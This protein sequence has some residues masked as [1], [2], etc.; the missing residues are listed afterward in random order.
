MGLSFQLHS[1][2]YTICRLECSRPRNW[3]RLGAERTDRKK[4][5][6]A[7]DLREELESRAGTP[8]FGVA[9]AASYGAKAPEGHRPSDFMR[10]ARSIVLVGERML[11]A[12]LD[13]IP[14]TRQEYTANFHVA[15]DRLNHV[16]F[17][18]AGVLQAEGYRAF[19]VPY[20]E[21]PGWNLEGRSPLAL[22]LLRH[23]MTAQRARPLVEASLW[24]NLSY[25]HMA[26]EAGL[27]ELG[28]N[29]LLLHPEHG[30]RV[31]FVALLTD[32]EMQAG[33]PLE[34]ALCRPEL[35]GHACARACPAGALSEEGGRTDRPACLK[36]YIKLGIPGQSGVRCG[37]C[38]AKCPV[39]RASF[40]DAAASR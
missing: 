33:S 14:V 6:Q 21:M 4:A 36:Y 17:E 1:K 2:V 18:L 38:V 25:R 28:L 7:L 26:V 27:G 15:N 11:D 39:Y 40:R 13:G 34:P 32:A 23:V 16:L 20:K 12:P 24:D 29:N 22:K 10:E 37:L 5:R 35:C 8:V 3:F 30:P 31:R 9:D 19:P